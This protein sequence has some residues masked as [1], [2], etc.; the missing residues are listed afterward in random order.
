MKIILYIPTLWLWLHLCSANPTELEQQVMFGKAGTLHELVGMVHVRLDLPL[1][2]L[3]Q[4]CAVLIEA[5]PK[6]Q[7]DMLQPLLKLNR[8]KLSM[9]ESLKQDC[10][11]L[12]LE[13]QPG[14]S[15]DSLKSRTRTQRS[16][17][18][19][20]VTSVLT[21][22]GLDHLLGLTTDPTSHLVVE[23]KELHRMQ[24]LQH[25]ELQSLLEKLDRAGEEIGALRGMLWIDS[26]IRRFNEMQGALEALFERWHLG[27][28]MLD[29]HRLPRSLV[30]TSLAQEIW[31]EVERLAQSSGGTP[32]GGHASTLYATPT[33]S[34]STDG[35]M[36]IFVHVPVVGRVRDWSL[37]VYRDSP[38]LIPTKNGELG[39]AW[40]KPEHE[41]ISVTSEREGS[42][43]ALTK[44]DLEQCLRIEQNFF[45]PHLL[46]RRKFSAVCIAKLFSNQLEQLTETCDT[47]LEKTD[48]TAVRLNDG[49]LLYS[50]SQTPVT[51][52]CRNGSFQSNLR[53]G[54]VKLPF[55]NGCQWRTP[56]LSLLGGAKP[57]SR[58]LE[59]VLHVLPIKV[60]HFG[61]ELQTAT[62]TLMSRT[63]SGRKTSLQEL[64]KM[65]EKAEMEWERNEHAHRVQTH[66]WVLSSGAVV[67]FTIIIGSVVYN[68]RDLWR[69]AR[70]AD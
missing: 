30:S 32:L 18:S 62:Q 5:E 49:W 47:Y 16:L 63:K 31:T 12:L 59:K 2:K 38:I 48:H 9:R 20:V 52:D 61:Q 50:K 64:I 10:E 56:E 3:A 67:L 25:H 40:I 66:L 27:R 26:E 54:L 14:N 34:L 8:T 37:F 70:E 17:I 41:F 51:L 21:F 28:E 55:H 29:L 24:R 42:Y 6:L 43:T 13:F 22:L 11:E 15:L 65:E 57:L 23:V 33:S 68:F 53:E 46:L 7:R 58:Y 4:T 39:L 36:I 69:R 35:H 19:K 1:L 45:C 44:S 60:E